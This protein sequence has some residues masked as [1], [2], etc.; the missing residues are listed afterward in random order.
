MW[1]AAGSTVA[2]PITQLSVSM[3]WITSAKVRILNPAPREFMSPSW[4]CPAVV[5]ALNGMF[6]PAPA[7]RPTPDA[8]ADC[9]LEKLYRSDD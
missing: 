9:A 6:G 1:I 3:G 4:I 5:Q 7:L 2:R 8:G